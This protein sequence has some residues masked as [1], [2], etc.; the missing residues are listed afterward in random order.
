VVDFTLRAPDSGD[1]PRV[2]GQSYTS[3]D[4]P[5]RF[6]FSTSPFDSEIQNFGFVTEIT[7]RDVPEP[8]VTILVVLGAIMGLMAGPIL[9]GGKGLRS[10]CLRK[11]EESSGEHILQ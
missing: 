1:T 4:G 3:P 5:A 6:V 8:S 7:Y 10:R 2:D 11:D 9:L